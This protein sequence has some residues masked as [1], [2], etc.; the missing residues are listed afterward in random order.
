MSAAVRLRELS[1]QRFRNLVDARVSV[2]APFVVLCGRNGEGKTNTLE[3][4]HLLATLKPLRGRRVRELMRWGERSAAVSGRVA[5]NGIEQELSVTLDGDG[6]GAFL[7]DRKVTDLADYFARVRAVSFTP[8]DA[9]IVTGEPGR[10][11]NW[12]D[13]AAFTAR[14][15]HLDQVRALRRVLDQ[16]AALLRMERPDPA[17]LDVLDDQLASLG[18][19][20]VQRRQE[21]LDELMPHVRELHD[22]IAGGHGD[23]TL[24]L[25]SHAKGE[26]AA[27]RVAALREKLGATR[28]R[29]LDRRT[30]LAGPQL[31]DVRATLDGR[32]AR[33]FASRGQV[34]SIVLALKLAE[35][36]A[37]RAR[38]TVPMFLLDD[39]SSELDAERTGRLVRHVS[40]LGAQV[41]ATTTDPG[42]VRAAL[43]ITDT[44]VIT[45]EAGALTVGP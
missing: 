14:P 45:V 16:K 2:D 11:R 12:L 33:D 3:A 24:T 32:A 8:S 43:P 40:E 1:F 28:E 29:E 5:L 17:F 21:M 44:L 42:P 13:R 20:L 30:T 10:R 26:N 18:G 25:Q 38:G 35:M 19:A 34:R 39:V 6:R 41:L 23:L 7:D 37:A 22:G 36:V 27:E 15:A 31:D 4:A 9:E